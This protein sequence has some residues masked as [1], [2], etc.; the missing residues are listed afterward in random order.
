MEQ[1]YLILDRDGSPIEQGYLESPVSAEVLQF[2]LS[3]DEEDLPD[4][5]GHSKVQLIGLDDKSP[6]M[7]GEIMRQRGNRLAIKQLGSLGPEA[8]E[9]LRVLTNFESVMYPVSGSWKGQ[10][11][12]RGYDLSCGGLAF[13]TT[14]PLSPREIVEAVLPVTDQPLVLRMRVLREL[15]P[16]GSTPLYAA[17]FIDLCIDE[18]IFIRKA[19][20][21]IQVQRGA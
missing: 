3:R 10:R 1:L 13:F 4:L 17:R 2:R 15:P 16:K 21:S 9:N 19:V 6:S 11:S 7:R 20:F 18:E 5:S 8:R 12:I 14:Q